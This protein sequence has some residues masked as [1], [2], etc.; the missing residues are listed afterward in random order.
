MSGG[1]EGLRGAIPAAPSDP[2]AS[3]IYSQSALTE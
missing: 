1:V 3:I 2:T